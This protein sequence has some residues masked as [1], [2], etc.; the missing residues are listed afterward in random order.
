MEYF[1]QQQQLQQLQSPVSAPSFQ[2]QKIDRL[3]KKQTDRKESSLFQEV[4]MIDSALTSWGLFNGIGDSMSR[5]HN[6]LYSSRRAPFQSMH[7]QRMSL[8]MSSPGLEHGDEEGHGIPLGDRCKDEKRDGKITLGDP[9]SS[10]KSIVEDASLNEAENDIASTFPSEQTHTLTLDDTCSSHQKSIVVED[11]SLKETAKNMKPT[12]PEEQANSPDLP[13]NQSQDDEP[14]GN[15]TLYD[16]N[17][18]QKSIVED[19]SLQETKKYFDTTR[20]EEQTYKH[21]LPWNQSQDGESGGNMTLDEPHSFQTR[22]IDLKGASLKEG[23]TNIE[24]SNPEGPSHIV[25]NVGATKTKR[26]PFE[27][28]DMAGIKRRVVEGSIGASGVAWHCYANESIPL[29]ILYSATD[30]QAG[31]SEAPGSLDVL[32]KHAQSPPCTLSNDDGAADALASSSEPIKIPLSNQTSPKTPDATKIEALIGKF[33]SPGVSS[34]SLSLNSSI[35]SP[36][37]RVTSESGCTDD[38]SDQKP[39]TTSKVAASQTELISPT[40]MRSENSSNFVSSEFSRK[41]CGMTINASLAVADP[42]ILHHDDLLQVSSVYTSRVSFSSEK[43]FLM[44]LSLFVH[45]FSE[46]T[47][48]FYVA[49]RCEPL[50]SPSRLA[51]SVKLVAS[52]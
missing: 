20:P 33:S 10:Q 19:A 46:H 9:H 31:E 44:L 45:L 42:S 2:N 38:S 12:N 47:V 21:D 22:S 48:N 29:E 4:N 8:F 49:P 7:A 40:E 52:K 43:T 25:K 24:S 28:P 39:E 34:V 11:A 15:M 23:E 41:N 37:L 1:D 3:S 5:P 30:L 51:L 6:N 18:S 26:F 36:I 13:W 27:V 16:P 14:G 35:S 50:S 32:G 17:S